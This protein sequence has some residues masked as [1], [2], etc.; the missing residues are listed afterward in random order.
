MKSIIFTFIFIALFTPQLFSQVEIPFF[1]KMT[2][3]WEGNY[4]SDGVKFDE[5][6]MT[7]WILNHNYFELLVKSKIDD[8]QHKSFEDKE[9]YFFTLDNEGNLVGGKMD[10]NGFNSTMN[11]KGRLEES[12]EG[13]RVT[14]EGKSIINKC[15]M[16]FELKNKHLVRTYEAIYNDALPVKRKI[17]YSK[18]RDVHSLP[19]QYEGI[20]RPG[21]AYVCHLSEDFVTVFDTKTN[22]L[23]GKIPCGKNSDHICFSTDRNTGYISNFS[24]NNLTVFDRKTNETTA[25]VDA[26]ENPTFLL[27][28][29]NNI[30]ISHESHDGLWILDGTTNTITKKLKEGTGLLYLI[31]N[32]NKIYQP[33]IFIPYLYIIDPVSLEIVKRINTGGRPMDMTITQN[34][35]YG[36]MVNYDFNEV[37]KFDTKTDE[38]I[39]HIKDVNHPRGIASSPDGKLVYVS[40]VVDG[41]VYVINTET[42]SITAAIDGF[43]MPVW[44]EF[45][46]D[47]KFAYVLNQDKATIV[48]IDTQTNTIIETFNVASN[49]ISIVID[50]R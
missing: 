22:E 49:P 14:L 4:E 44:I 38:M 12:T 48:V 9:L 45:T 46:A 33:Q 42:D 27:T 28:V 1:D 36:Y 16:T 47:G 18:V 31:E 15:I 2:G 19:M 34:K 24:S 23:V 29:K 3:R 6:I 20:G 41:R 35:R 50:N 10:N 30:F 39:K 25:T 40:N 5:A 17:V 7:T 32:E 26:G 11:F 37:T 21:F 8:Y 43:S 13:G